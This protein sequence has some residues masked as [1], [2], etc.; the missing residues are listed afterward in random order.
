VGEAQLGER[1]V[2]HVRGRRCAP[3]EPAEAGL[4]G[5][6]VLRLGLQRRH[7]EVGG[8]VGPLRLQGPLDEGPGLVEPVHPLVALPRERERRHPPGLERE[9]PLEVPEGLVRADPQRGELGAEVVQLGRLRVDLDRLAQ[10]ALALVE[11]AHDAD[12]VPDRPDRLGAVRVLGEDGLVAGD[13]LA[14]AALALQRAGLVEGS[15]QG[16]I[17]FASG[18]GTGGAPVLGRGP[19]DRM[20]VGGRRS[21][22]R[23]GPPCDPRRGR[24]YHPRMPVVVRWFLRLLPLNPISVRLVQNGSRR[25]MH[26]VIRSAYLAVLIIVLL[27]SLLL[28]AGAG[29]GG[30]PSYRELAE[31]GATSFVIIAY[32]QIALICILAPV[33]MASAIAQE[34][35]PKTWDI[36][37][38]TPL[39]AG[40][41][42]LGNLVGRLFFVLALLLASLPLFATTQYF[43]G[44]PASSIF[45]SYAVAACAALLVGSIAIALSVSRVAGRRAVFTFYVVVVSYI[46]VTAALDTLIGSGGGGGGGVTFWT[47]LNPFL[48]LRALLNPAT[49]PRAEA[50]SLTGVAALFLETPVRAWCLLSSGVSVALLVVSTFTVRTGGLQRAAGQSS[51][52]PWYRRMMGLGA[53]GSEYRPPREVSS[54]PIAWREAAARNSTFWKIVARWSFVALGLLGALALIG[55]YHGG[56][57]SPGDFRAILMAAVWTETAVITLIAINMAATAVSRER[58]DGTLDLILTT[59]IT[60][61]MYLTG[62]L[63][64]LV[65]YLVPL[66]LVPVGTLVLAGGYV[67]T[68]GLGRGSVAVPATFAQVPTDVPLVLPE[69]GLLSLAVL[70]PFLAFCVIIGLNWSLKSKGTIGSVVATVGVVGVV[71]GTVGL[72]GWQSGRDINTIG[73]GLAALNPITLL[74]AVIEPDAAL[75]DTVNNGPAGV[76]GA[77]VALAIGAVIAAS[78]H[79]AVVWGVHASMVRGFDFTVRKLAGTK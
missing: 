7:Q 64:G 49:Y 31:A 20:V 75:A 32:L 60:P 45:G 6:E 71:G 35:N 76:T 46:A 24:R 55:V 51:K 58:E 14:E 12:R 26:N 1:A 34:S 11:P 4:G 68:G 52:I 62:K 42:V 40:Q 73:A 29:T 18:R 19:G 67:L 16:R 63:K 53:E 56:S 2:V 27:W 17:G 33:F 70:L 47:A 61:G 5:V 72:C 50:G 65:A 10:Q 57:L 48:A 69:A 9:R 43:G 37:L 39:T 41:I 78:V 54:N 23:R 59:P 21:A 22:G 28:N 77:R 44:V 3:D 79:T 15:G 8:G 38:T 66:M 30:G 13:R 74:Y 36:L 25:S